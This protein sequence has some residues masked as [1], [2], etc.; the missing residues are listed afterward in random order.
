ML[1]F[2]CDHKNLLL[3]KIVLDIKSMHRIILSTAV[4][5][6]KEE[7]NV[8]STEQRERISGIGLKELF[9]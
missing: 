2:S 4:V 6:L 8:D 1:Y 5:I 7:K 9:D 3:E